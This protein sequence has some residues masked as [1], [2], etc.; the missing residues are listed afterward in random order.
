MNRDEAVTRIQRILGF[1]SD[2]SEEIIDALVDAQK[3]SGIS[4]LASLVSLNGDS[5]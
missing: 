1:R 5:V 3:F 2:K 4:C